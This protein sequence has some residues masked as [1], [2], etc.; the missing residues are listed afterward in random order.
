MHQFN[1]VHFDI[2]PANVL[3]AM[4]D[5][6]IEYC[7]ICDFGFAMVLGAERKVVQGINRPELGG[8]TSQYA[9]PEV[10]GREENLNS[11]F[12]CYVLFRCLVGYI[13]GEG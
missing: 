5:D 8:F 4:K 6:E 9:S 12:T 1:I 2:K 13:W 11:L 10:R 3:L 7:V